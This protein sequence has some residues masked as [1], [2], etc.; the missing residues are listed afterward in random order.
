MLFLIIERIAS[1]NDIRSAFYT[2]PNSIMFPQ[3]SFH[4]LISSTTN[5]WL[6]MVNSLR[7]EERVGVFADCT[8]YRYV[9]NH[10][11]TFIG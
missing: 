8:S 3:H 6:T 2:R 10:H 5:R 4:M 9:I 1:A 11:K 7:Q